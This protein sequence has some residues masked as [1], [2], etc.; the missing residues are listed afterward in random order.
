[1]ILSIASV[2][3]IKECE[4]TILPKDI[5]CMVIT[6]WQYPESCEKYGVIFFN[7]TPSILW[8]SNLTSYGNTGYCNTTF[9]FTD[10]FGSFNYNISNGDTGSITVEPEVNEMEIA[11]AIFAIVFIVIGIWIIFFRG[12]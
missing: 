7:D 8:V 3:A 11:I 10:Y 12:K 1:M 2:S 4:R 9:N 6:T 5:P